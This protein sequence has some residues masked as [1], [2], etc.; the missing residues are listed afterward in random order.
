MD[1]LN[2]QLDMLNR[3]MDMLNRQMDMLNRQMD[4]LNYQPIWR[5]VSHLNFLNEK[6][7]H[8]VGRRLLFVVLWPINSSKAE[9][10][11]W[12]RV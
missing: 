3:Q 9:I 7:N 2:R 1:M 10:L 4:M 8:F 6:Q 5:I 11:I 12:N